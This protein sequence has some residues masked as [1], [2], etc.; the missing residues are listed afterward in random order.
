M[1][2]SSDATAGADASDAASPEDTAGATVDAGGLADA[3]AM[4]PDS[5]LDAGERGDALVVG[6]VPPSDAP[7]DRP[8]IDAVAIDVTSA[9]A[10]TTADVRPVDAGGDVPRDVPATGDVPAA[11]DVPRDAPAT[12]ADAS[13]AGSAPVITVA[14][15]TSGQVIETCSESE[16]PVYFDFVAAV[17][18]ATPVVSVGARWIT[19]DGPEAPPPATLS[20]GPYSFRRQV[21]GPTSSGAPALSVF[22]IR[23]AWRVE[24]TAVDACGRRT[25]VSQPFSLTFTT[26]RCPNP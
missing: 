8:V 24:L 12:A 25:T 21:G 19:P 11:G 6:D 10:G 16:M 13:C 22:G 26:R 5:G 3:A 1:Q 17:S 20:A 9:D 23:G 2:V 4:T 15:P 7:S 18:P 14:S